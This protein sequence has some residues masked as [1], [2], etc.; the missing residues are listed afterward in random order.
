MATLEEIDWVVNYCTARTNA[1]IGLLHGQHVMSTASSA[2]VPF[3][4]LELDCIDLFKERYGLGTGFVEHTSTIF[5]P[6]LAIAKGASI[7]TKH[8]APSKNLIDGKI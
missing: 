6:S 1:D 7:V 8:L 4:L 3:E 2:G 5:V